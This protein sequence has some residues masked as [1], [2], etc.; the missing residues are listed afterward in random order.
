MDLVRAILL[1]IENNEKDNLRELEIEGFT[2][3]EII[4]HCDMLDD[5]GMFLD[6]FKEYAN[7]G[8]YY[9]TVNKLS[10]KGHNF[11]NDIR[12]NSKWQ[13]VKTYIKEHALP[14]TIETIIA[15]IQNKLG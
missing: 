15:I 3:D 4:Y 6:Y 7:G 11:L 2:R 12:D 5:A 10:W 8:V 1:N 13:K 14:V 9:F